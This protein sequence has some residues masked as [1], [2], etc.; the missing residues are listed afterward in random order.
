MIEYLDEIFANLYSN[1]I[2]VGKN[3]DDDEDD[4]PDAWSL[5]GRQ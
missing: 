3:Y 5:T 4:D 2:F 1:D